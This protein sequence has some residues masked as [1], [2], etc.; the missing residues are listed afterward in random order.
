MHHN[1][2]GRRAGRERRARRR[3]PAPLAALDRQPLAVEQRAERARRRPAHRRLPPFEPGA[4]LERPPSRMGAA[5]RDA[6]LGDRRRH[7]LRMVQRRARAVGEPGHAVR[8]IA[9]EPLVAGLRADREAPAQ[10]RHRLLTRFRCQHEAHPLL[11]DTGLRPH[12]RQ[13]LPA[14]HMTCYPCRRSILS[15]MYPV[16]TPRPSPARGEGGAGRCP[17]SPDEEAKRRPTPRERAAK[18]PAKG[19]PPP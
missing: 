19:P 14:D 18:A 3:Y 12:H 2:V 16:R 11:H 4:H 10:R 5:R 15:P 17:S 9:P 13:L 6:G 1:L 7:R 8:A